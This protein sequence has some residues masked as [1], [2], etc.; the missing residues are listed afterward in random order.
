[1]N[2]IE[3]CDMDTTHYRIFEM[4]RAINLGMKILLDCQNKS[5]ANPKQILGTIIATPHTA[6]RLLVLT[7]QPEEFKSD[8]F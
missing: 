5:G 1:M 4:F 2:K 6:F 7:K 8:Q 3:Q